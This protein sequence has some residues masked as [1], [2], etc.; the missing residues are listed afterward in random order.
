MPSSVAQLIGS[1]RQILVGVDMWQT[2]GLAAFPTLP[3]TTSIFFIRSGDCD[4]WKIEVKEFESE[5]TVNS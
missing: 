4:N 3:F 1:G 5:N 2:N